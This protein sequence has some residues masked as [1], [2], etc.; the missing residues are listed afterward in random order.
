MIGLEI[1]D[2][3]PE[4]GQVSGKRFEE[5]GTFVDTEGR[6]A[7]TFAKQLWS[8]AKVG[9]I[10]I[11]IFGDARQIMGRRSRLA[12]DVPVELLPVDIDCTAQMRNGALGCTGNFEVLDQVRHQWLR[13][14]D[15]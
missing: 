14:E 2:V 13:L 8:E 3:T 12:V 10:K 15:E 9:C 7:K 4:R 11:E 1:A 5:I 6:F